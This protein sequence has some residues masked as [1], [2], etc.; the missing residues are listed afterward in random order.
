M[1]RSSTFACRPRFLEPGEGEDLACRSAVYTHPHRGSIT[2]LVA[3]SRL[4]PPPLVHTRSSGKPPDSRDPCETQH[5][6]PPPLIRPASSQ[7]PAR[8]AI[9]GRMG[10]RTLRPFPPGWWRRTCLPT[11]AAA[12][13][14]RRP[15]GRPSGP[16]AGGPVPILRQS[17][18]RSPRIGTRVR[19]T[20]HRNRDTGPRTPGP[21]GGRRYGGTWHGRDPSAR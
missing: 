15:P 18:S 16:V 10:T 20:R 4:S 2:E 6:R 5:L 19:E 14:V 11:R 7:A 21:A 17:G 13:G 3:A 9:L 1:A 8:G 12:C